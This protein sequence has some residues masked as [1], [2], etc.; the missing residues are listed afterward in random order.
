MSK[1]KASTVQISSVS[2]VDAKAIGAQLGFTG[3]YINRLAAA[4]RIP[5]HGVRNGVKVYR[6]FD[7]EEV[8]VALA[9]PVEESGIG[10]PKPV[11]RV[12]R[13]ETRRTQAS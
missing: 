6:R 5:W 11:Q 4:G 2:L 10:K 7:P 1:S 9:H 13:E 3:E 12:E 8:K